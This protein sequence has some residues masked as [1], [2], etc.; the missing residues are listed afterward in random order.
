MPD[1]NDGGG[2]MKIDELLQKL[3]MESSEDIKYI[4]SFCELMELD[5]EISEDVF[6]QL[7]K[8]I[9]FETLKEL[10]D[11]YLEE[12][13]TGIPDDCIDFYTYFSSYKRNL[14]GMMNYYLE[15]SNINAAVGEI[16]R[17]REWY[18]IPDK[19]KCTDLDSSSEFGSSVCN[20]LILGRMERLAMG[21][22]SFDFDDAM[23]LEYDDFEEYADKELD[24]EDYGEPDG[25]DSDITLIDKDNPV[26][27]GVD[28]E[29]CEGGDFLQ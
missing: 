13:M 24:R 15:E 16:Y 4:E 20:S 18:L 28:Y 21:R 7:F 1:M 17:F 22:Y 6:Y 3:D 10:A 14:G 23:D 9:E 25:D 29:D 27:D 2:E 26:I 11:S 5:E 12:I 8:G 19:V